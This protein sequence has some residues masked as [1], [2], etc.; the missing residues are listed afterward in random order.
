M[1]T[2]FIDEL[3]ITQVEYI[4]TMTHDIFTADKTHDDVEI[5]IDDT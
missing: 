4:Q 3:F 1:F 2:K 5:T